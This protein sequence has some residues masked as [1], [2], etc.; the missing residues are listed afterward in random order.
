MRADEAVLASHRRH[1]PRIGPRNIYVWTK[2]IWIREV[3]ANGSPLVLKRDL[4]PKSPFVKKYACVIICLR[5]AYTAGVVARSS[6][7]LN[8]IRRFNKLQQIIDQRADVTN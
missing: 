8:R 7:L 2:R 6:G 4:V 1:S 5:P 3:E